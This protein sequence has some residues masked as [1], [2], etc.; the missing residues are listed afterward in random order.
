MMI[1]LWDEQRPV[2]QSPAITPSAQSLWCNYRAATSPFNALARAHGKH[3]LVWFSEYC[4]VSVVRETA[5]GMLRFLEGR[6]I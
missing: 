1:R 3:M 6:K 4:S 2:H 5:A